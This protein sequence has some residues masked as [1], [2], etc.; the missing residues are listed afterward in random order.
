[1]VAYLIN[2]TGDNLP[3]DLAEFLIK[4]NALVPP[5]WKAEVGNALVSNLRRGR[6]PSERLDRIITEISQLPISAAP[7]MAQEEFL[8]TIRFAIANNL[9]FY[10]ATYVKLAADHEATL[11]TLDGAMRAAARKLSVELIPGD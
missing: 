9:T 7:D 6:I 10:D 1:M 8:A 3:L 4:Q 2:E 5:H 11:A